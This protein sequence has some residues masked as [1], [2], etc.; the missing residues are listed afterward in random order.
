MRSNALS[1][2]AVSQQAGGDSIEDNERPGRADQKEQFSNNDFH[3]ILDMHHRP[4]TE[5]T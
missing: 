3:V 1:R 2:P 4:K 5:E